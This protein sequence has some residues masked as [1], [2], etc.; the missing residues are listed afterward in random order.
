MPFEKPG[1]PVPASGRG[2]DS[3]AAP[4]QGQGPGDNHQQA[5]PAADIRKQ[6]DPPVIK[7]NDRP[8]GKLIMPGCL[9]SAKRQLLAIATAFVMVGRGTKALIKTGVQ[10]AP[11]RNLVPIAG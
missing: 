7:R 10:G 8:V 6:R 5:E 9:R 4:Y 1:Y 3:I 2:L 11:Y